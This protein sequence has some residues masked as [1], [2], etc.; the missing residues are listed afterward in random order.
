MATILWPWPQNC[1]KATKLWPWPQM[2]VPWELGIIFSFTIFLAKTL[3]IVYACTLS[4]A[5]LL[6]YRYSNQEQ[7]KK[8]ENNTV[9]FSIR[10]TTTYT[11]S[12]SLK[13]RL[14]LK[15][16]VYN[17]I[18]TYRIIIM[19]IVIIL[20]VDFKERETAFKRGTPVI[21]ESAGLCDCAY[22]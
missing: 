3:S 15:P 2:L 13:F 11:T 16:D 20:K 9:L 19:N 18:S 7:R 17:I 4:I 5:L 22:R 1:G 8:K 14:A 6:T 10:N 12:S 21:F